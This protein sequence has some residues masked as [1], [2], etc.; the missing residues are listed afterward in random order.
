MH[1]IIN[2]PNFV[3]NYSLYG[4]EPVTDKKENILLAALQL[5]SNEG[6]NVVPT[7]K[8]AKQAGVSEGL[9]FKHFD[10]KKGL[11]DAIMEDAELR[12]NQVFAPVLFETDP[13]KTISKIIET[14]FNIREEEYNYWRLQFKLKWETEYYNPQKMK[15]IIDKL[16]WAF[17]ELGYKD[18]QNEAE[19]L[20]QIVESVSVNI[21]REG[22]KSQLKFKSFLQQK[23][24][25]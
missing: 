10:N 18:P 5:F 14:P 11:L 1:R 25:V 4:K 2:P 13:I 12:V 16:Q 17:S 7:S 9:I 19:L 21:L 3:S 24:K 8:I 15:P 23:Y 22:L 20:S 6:Y